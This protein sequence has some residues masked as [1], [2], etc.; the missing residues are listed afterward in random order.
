MKRIDLILASAAMMAAVSCTTNTST[1]DVIPLPQEI[2][3]SSKMLDASVLATVS[4]AEGLDNEAEALC[5]ALSSRVECEQVAEGGKATLS[6]DPTMAEEEYVLVVKPG[7]LSVQGGSPKAVFHGIQTIAQELL[8]YDGKLKVGKIHDYPRYGWRGYMLDES[9]HFFGIDQ[10]K[11]TLDMMSFYKLNKFH[12]HLTD[13]PGWRIEIKAYPELTKVGSIG[14]LSD[15]TAAPAFY[16]QDQ[17]REVVEYAAK[18]HID[19]VPEIDMPG[20]AA[21]ATR[22]Y[23]EL[24]VGGAGSFTYNPGKEEVYT[25]IENVLKEVVGLFPYEYL[26]I[27]GDEVALGNQ[28]WASD[29]YIKALMEKEG[30]ETIEEAEAY[31]L[32]WIAPT[33]ASLGKKMIAWDDVLELGAGHCGTALTW[34]R[35][36]RVDH[37][38]QGLD[39]DYEMILCPRLPLYY[40]FVQ[41]TTHL[42]GRRTWKGEV[43]DCSEEDVYAFPDDLFAQGEFAQ[44][45]ILGMQANLWSEVVKTSERREFLTYPRMCAL[46]ESA[47]TLA[48]NKDYVSFSSRLEPSY[49]LFD[50]LGIYYY[51]TR[52]PQRHAEPQ[53]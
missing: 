19:V 30:M 14:C 12:W 46:A 3:V 21:S 39:E 47:W 9:R 20:H 34:W 10:V 27:G 33:V 8:A 32:K 44:D 2:Q 29:P 49:K 5:K 13:A 48:E 16:T 42:A 24:G 17:I 7:K 41:D 51:D 4:A 52:D 28:G 15:P 1:V 40:D 45:G 38:S 23:P 50:S 53:L 18:L 22:S 25:F 35:H 31:F 6:V 26:H 11:Q 36:D 43:V 37:V